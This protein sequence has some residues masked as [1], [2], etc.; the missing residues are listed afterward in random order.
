MPS[1]PEWLSYEKTVTEIP[2]TTIVLGGHTFRCT[3]V[4][5]RGFLRIQKALRVI[6]EDDPYEGLKRLFAAHG[7]E[8]PKQARILEVFEAAA[9]L[10]RLDRI[11][12]VLPF[13][14]D[15]EE[16]VNLDSWHYESRR[17]IVW[18]DVL[19]QAYG[20]T[21]EQILSMDVDAILCFVQ[22]AL[23]ANQLEKEWEHSLSTIA[24]AHNAKTKKTTYLPLSRPFWM[25]GVL[26]EP[27]KMR[28]P[29]SLLPLGVVISLER[30][31][32]QT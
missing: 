13:L 24:Y 30:K 32:V 11:R 28:I 25:R 27:K 6:R 19:A 16:E 22:E 17:V 12:G 20:W 1:E 5:F 7:V 9:A 3:R 2:S 29:K 10:I 14:K 23:V 26:K 18:M 8:V 21:G 4:P 31:G 15:T